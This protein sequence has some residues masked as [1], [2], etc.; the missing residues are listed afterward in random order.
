MPVSSEISRSAA[1]SGVSP[2]S[3]KPCGKPQERPSLT[4]QTSWPGSDGRTTTPPAEISLGRN[5]RRGIA[6][7]YS[8]CP[9][10]WLVSSGAPRPRGVAWPNTPPCQ[11]GDRR[12]ES[13]R[14]RQ[15]I[16][17]S[18]SSEA[19]VQVMVIPARSGGSG[20]FGSISVSVSMSNLLIAQSRYH[21]WSEGITYQGAAAV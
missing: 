2:G 20:Y 1:C 12:F 3:I 14:G 9:E 21:L 6:E 13:D 8:G 10:Q 11:G 15:P 18:G 7:P 19:A 5:G 16:S 4:T 17:G